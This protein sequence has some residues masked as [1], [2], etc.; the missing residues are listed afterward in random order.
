MGSTRTLFSASGGRS[1]FINL[2]VEEG[3]ERTGR[4]VGLIW[5]IHWRVEVGLDIV[6]L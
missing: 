3:P 6:L 1:A 2:K 5:R 4:S